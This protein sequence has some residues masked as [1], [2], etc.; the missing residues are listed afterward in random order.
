MTKLTHT[1]PIS[2]VASQGKLVAT[3]GYDNRVIL[4]DVDSGQAL[5][6]GWHDHLVNH[7]EFSHDGK[8]LVTASS[9]YSARLWVLPEMRLQAVLAGHGDDVDM[10][11][12]SP[13]DQKIATCALDRAVR[14]YDRLGICMKELRGHTGNIIS[15]MW[16]ADGNRLVSSSVDGT[17]REWDVTSGE[18]LHCHELAV[19]T[20]TIAF[21]QEERIIA[22]DDEGRIAII[23]DQRIRFYP[24]HR[25]GIKKLVCNVAQRIVATLSYDRTLAIW[26]IDEHGELV[27]INRTEIPAVIWSR[28]AAVLDERRLVV[29][30]FGTRYAIYN[31][32]EN[33][34]DVDGVSAGNAINAVSLHRGDVYTVG[35][36][37]K[38]CRN[39]KHLTD[40]GSLCNFLS[41]S[42]DMLFTGGQL[43]T[44]FNALN[45]DS[46]YQHHSPLNCGISF[47]RSGVPHLAIG[48]YTGEILVFRIENQSNIEL[49][50][51]LKIFGNA[52]KGLACSGQQIF[53]VCANTAISWIDME[54]L[55][56]SEQRQHSHEKIINACATIGNHGFASVSRD[57]TLR[58][59]M[60]GVCET[61]ESPHPNSVKTLCSSDDG[62]VLLSGSY[63][64]TI[65]SFDVPSRSWSGFHRPTT[66]GISS[67]TYD[68]SNRRFI[69]ASYDG[70]L[71][72]IF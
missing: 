2:S 62:N 10:A 31:W 55:H 26:R 8:S 51:T 37:G 4:W 53:S 18:Q 44:L 11:S 41:S 58:L 30:T 15:V 47:L 49:V 50:D 54:S 19:R 46:L 68:S 27:E 60:N 52:V 48:T 67:I 7:C 33:Q 12:F 20:D 59:W 28:A 21:D 14:I 39:G 36:A 23:T 6:Q 63:G 5:S 56:V 22:G 35:D 43:G 64:G 61:Y 9:D 32:I 66:S 71:H 1:G 38:V 29:G 34:W 70:S 17:V 57:R 65:A 3:A 40:M 25:A 13:D 69:A 16:S 24:A 42:D 72:T 45:G